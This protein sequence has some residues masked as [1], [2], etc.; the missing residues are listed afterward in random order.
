MPNDPYCQASTGIEGLNCGFL[1]LCHLNLEIRHTESNSYSPSYLWKFSI[2][3][4]C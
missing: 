1:G 2:H 3:D 4:D